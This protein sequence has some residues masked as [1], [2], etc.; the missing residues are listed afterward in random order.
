[1]IDDVTDID[2]DNEMDP[3]LLGEDPIVKLDVGVA[4]SA[5][6]TL[7]VGE[8]DADRFGVSEVVAVLDADAP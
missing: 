4:D 5:A 8:G 2:A 7:T 1:M 3:L 6:V